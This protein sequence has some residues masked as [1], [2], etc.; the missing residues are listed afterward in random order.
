MLLFL[1]SIF[2]TMTDSSFWAQLVSTTDIDTE[3][4]PL[5]KNKVMIG[6]NQGLTATLQNLMMYFICVIN[7][8]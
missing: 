1:C 7:F 2:G 5:Q 6:R 8:Y 3:P 4:I